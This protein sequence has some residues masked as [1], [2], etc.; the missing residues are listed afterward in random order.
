M[1]LFYRKLK[2]KVKVMLNGLKICY[3]DLM[4]WRHL[5]VLRRA[6]NVILNVFLNGPLLIYKDNVLFTFY[7]GV[8]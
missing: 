1:A 4:I 8:K 3:V 2:T 6:K 5:M 7:R